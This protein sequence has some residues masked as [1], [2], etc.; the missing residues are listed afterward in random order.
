MSDEVVK[1]KSVKF[2]PQLRLHC[3]TLNKSFN[4][5]RPWFAHL[6][7]EWLEHQGTE[8]SFVRTVIYRVK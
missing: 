6:E 5:S 1:F 8:N 4:L 7:N 2:S 3:V